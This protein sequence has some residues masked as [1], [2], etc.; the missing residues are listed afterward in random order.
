M[1]GRHC[2]LRKGAQVTILEGSACATSRSLHA[3]QPDT[4]FGHFVT[5]RPLHFRALYQSS[6]LFAGR[7]TSDGGDVENN[8]LGDAI[9]QRRRSKSPETR[10]SALG[11]RQG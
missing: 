5:F 7:F 8:K 4:E 3:F 10:V 9:T 6:T 1:G 2:S 11:R